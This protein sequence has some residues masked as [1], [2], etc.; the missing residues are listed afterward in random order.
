[1]MRRAS[2]ILSGLPGGVYRMTRLANV[3]VAWW[4]R[5]AARQMRL[6]RCPARSSRPARTC[7]AP[8]TASAVR[9]ASVRAK[10]RTRMSSRISAQ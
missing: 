1:M 7:A 3:V 5:Q 4:S 6:S 2:R 9:A 10:P 8:E